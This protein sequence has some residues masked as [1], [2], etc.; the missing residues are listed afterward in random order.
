MKH[1][2]VE[3]V[4]PNRGKSEGG[5]P[6]LKL[7][8]GSQV[9][10]RF[11]ARGIS[12]VVAWVKKGS[13]VQKHRN[14]YEDEA[15]FYTGCWIAKMPEQVK[16]AGHKTGFSVAS[17][18]E[19]LTMEPLSEQGKQKTELVEPVQDEN[20]PKAVKESKNQLEEQD[21]KR[22]VISRQ[23]AKDEVEASDFEEDEEEEVSSA[24]AED[25]RP[26]KVIAYEVQS[27]EDSSEELFQVILADGQKTWMPAITLECS[28]EGKKL[29]QEFCKRK[30]EK[31]KELA[32]NF[33]K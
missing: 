14:L 10:S 18:E 8:E 25:E 22:N 31:R 3:R 30:G 29:V 2:K 16:S 24:S 12:H 32:K 4:Q 21:Q 19:Y 23:K 27:S 1:Q 28:E 6:M 5:K 11:F 17:K 13:F 20:R 15:L 7:P 26:I 33:K 9:V